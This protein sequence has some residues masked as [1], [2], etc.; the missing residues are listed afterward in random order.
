MKNFKNVEIGDVATD[1]CDFEYIVVAKDLGKNFDKNL[2]DYDST[3]AM[4]DYIN[5]SD[6]SIDEINEMEMIAVKEEDGTTL[7]FLYDYDGCYVKDEDD[8]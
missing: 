3:G 6:M 5:N 2:I 7:V 8:E 1:Y 4:I